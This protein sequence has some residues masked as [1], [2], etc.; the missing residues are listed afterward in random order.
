MLRDI[1]RYSISVFYQFV[2]NKKRGIIKMT[3]ILK[4]C[5]RHK[6]FLEGKEFYSFQ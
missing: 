2:Q 4:C 1:K 3:A 6:H 5:P